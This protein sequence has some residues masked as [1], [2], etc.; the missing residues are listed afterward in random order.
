[1]AI[2]GS[3]TDRN[4]IKGDYIVKFMRNYL[5]SNNK[6]KNF[7]YALAIILL[8]GISSF[9]FADIA[10]A[11]TNT[12]TSVAKVK[13]NQTLLDKSAIPK[14]DK[15]PYTEINKNIPYFTEAEKNKTTSFETYSRLDSLGRCGVAYANL[16]KEL[17]PTEER[18]KIGMVKPSGWHTVKYNDLV[19]GN[20]LYN[21]CHL[22]AFM[23]AGENANE[24]NLITGTRYMNTQGMLPFEEKVADYVE[25]TGNHVLYRITPEYTDN[26]LVADGVL[27]EAYSV[28]DKGKGICFNVYCYNV[29]PGVVINYA[30]GDSS[31]DTNYKSTNIQKTESKKDASVTAKTE[32][33]TATEA[34]KTDVAAAQTNEESATTVSYIA[35]K[36]TKKFHI[37]QCSSVGDMKEKNKW[38]FNGSRDELIAQGYVPCKRCYP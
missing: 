32:T 31:R 10:W 9:C 8:V 17:M 28:E 34:T 19:E 6:V 16:S 5:F 21:R 12:N 23:L 7:I 20:Y 30:T 11:A 33:K 29:Q 3:R 35:N 26:N 18:G 14:Y 13:Q 24:K 1:M 2:C 37:P 15:D 25:R 4:N 22:I 27:M 36:N 38:Y